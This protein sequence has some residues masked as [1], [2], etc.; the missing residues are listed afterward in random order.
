MS[1]SGLPSISERM[2]SARAATPAFVAAYVVTVLGIPRMADIDEM[3]TRW[4]RFLARKISI[5]ASHWASAPMKFV[6]AVALLAA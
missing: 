6:I 5:A 1:R 3:T 2:P 4:P